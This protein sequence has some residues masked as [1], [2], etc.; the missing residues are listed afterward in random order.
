MS[1]LRT[2][3]RD[4]V[5]P[6]LLGLILGSAVVYMIVHPSSCRYEEVC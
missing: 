6:T 3:V 5:M 4:L 2:L 1:R